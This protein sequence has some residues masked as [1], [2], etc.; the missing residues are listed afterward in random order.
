[1]KDRIKDTDLYY[2]FTDDFMFSLILTDSDGNDITF[3]QTKINF[4]ANLVTQT[5]VANE[6]GVRADRERTKVPLELEYCGDKF[7]DVEP[8][9]Q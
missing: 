8:E 9:I 1:M 6:E 3:D 7:G 2:P 5:W 4:Y